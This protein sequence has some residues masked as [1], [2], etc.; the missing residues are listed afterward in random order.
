[1]IFGTE[2]R[3]AFRPTLVSR[4]SPKIGVVRSGPF[5]PR[6]GRKS[7]RGGR[8]S[9]S[10]LLPVPWKVLLRL[11]LLLNVVDGSFNCSIRRGVIRMPLRLGRDVA[12][13]LAD[14]DVTPKDLEID[15]ELAAPASLLALL[16]AL[17]SAFMPRDVV[18][19]MLAEFPTPL[20]LLLPA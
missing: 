17:A 4:A 20:K 5:D 11:L 2:G 19:L 10:P 13:E 9:S 7:G 15:M 16:A 12:L 14:A 18:L 3:S 1:M 8:R 6:C